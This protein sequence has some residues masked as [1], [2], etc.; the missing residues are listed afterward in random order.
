MKGIMKKAASAA[1]PMLMLLGAVPALP[2]GAA[3]IDA[4]SA[5]VVEIDAFS[6]DAMEID[7]FSVDAVESVAPAAAAAAAGSVKLS[8]D[9]VLTLS[10]AVT[11]EQIWKYR[12]NWSVTSVVAK[13]GTNFVSIYAITE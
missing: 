13:P 5:D 4:F 9:G 2:A 11:K 6:A 1:V 8:E 12:G 7:A 3:E 10:G